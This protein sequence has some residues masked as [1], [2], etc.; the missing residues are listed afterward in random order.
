MFRWISEIAAGRILM[1][2]AGLMLAIAGLAALPVVPASA[3]TSAVVSYWG[4]S[5]YEDNGSTYQCG[6]TWQWS[7]GLNQVDEVYNPCSTRVWVHYVSVGT[8]Q[9]QAYCVNPFGGLAYDIPL[10]WN[11]TVTYSNIQLTAN[12]SPC[13]SGQTFAI[14]WETSNSQFHSQSYPCE[15]L[16][17]SITGE[18]V[19]EASNLGCDSRMWLHE[20]DGGTTGANSCVNPGAIAQPP[21]ETYW[22][23]QEVANQAPCDAGGPPYPY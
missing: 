16:T 14:A 9:V 19:E 20:S 23:V 5:H 2:T 10:Q 3:A 21:A 11:S 22:Q 8:G 18:F 12:A 13:D 15:D 1:I 4:T 17:L 6:T 7:Q